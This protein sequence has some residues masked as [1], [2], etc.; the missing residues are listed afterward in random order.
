MLKSFDNIH[1]M[2]YPTKIMLSDMA[3]IKIG[4]FDNIND[5]LA[6]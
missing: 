6:K 5:Y 2:S 4:Y 3:K 1:G